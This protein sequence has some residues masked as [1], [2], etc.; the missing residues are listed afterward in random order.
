MA[1]ITA[2]KEQDMIT[3]QPGTTYSCRSICNYDT[4]F[5]YHVIS[6]TAKFITVDDGYRVKRVGVKVHDG[7]EYANP[8]GVY[9]MCPSIY[10]DRTTNPA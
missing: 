7:I 6:R 3:F 9:S 8:D 1:T 10:A 5:S 4:I 2:T